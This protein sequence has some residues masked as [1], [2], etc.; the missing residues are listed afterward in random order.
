MYIYIHINIY[1]YIH[2]YTYIYIYSVCVGDL[3]LMG[4][5]C[6]QTWLAGKAFCQERFVVAVKIIHS[7]CSK[8]RF[9]SPRVPQKY[10]TC[11]GSR[12]PDFSWSL[13]MTIIHILMSLDWQSTWRCLIHVISQY[14]MTIDRGPYLISTPP[15]HIYPHEALKIPLSYPILLLGC[16]RYSHDWLVHTDTPQ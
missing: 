7:G 15:I 6:H 8:T 12:W 3:W 5:W 13:A 1:I 16:Y 14:F 4:L 11:L 9:D 10:P 2:I